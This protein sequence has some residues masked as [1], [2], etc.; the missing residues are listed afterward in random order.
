[1]NIKK[2]YTLLFCV[3]FFAGYRIGAYGAISVFTFTPA[4][5]TTLSNGN[6]YY[7]GGNSYAF[8]IQA[9]DLLAT[10]KSYWTQITLETREVATAR[11]SLVINVA[12][13]T[14]VSN[15]NS[16]GGTAFDV[17]SINDNT[18]DYRYLD[19]T[20][21]VRFRWSCTDFVMSGA[22]VA[23]GAANQIYGAVTANG[24]ATSGSSSNTYAYGVCT[25]I[26]ILNFAQS[27]DAGDARIS[28]WHSAFN[29]T[30]TAVYNVASATVA[31]G[32]GTALVSS[33]ALYY[34][35]G[36]VSSG[37]TS[38]AT[39]PDLTY[40]IPGDPAAFFASLALGDYQWYISLAMTNGQTCTSVNTLS[41]NV[42]RVEITNIEFLNGGGINSP[43]Y[44]NYSLPGT[45]VR[46]SAQMQHNSASLG[47]NRNMY[48]DTTIII[49]DTTNAPNTDIN[50]VIPNNTSQNTILVNVPFPTSSIN[51]D[52]TTPHTYQVRSVSGSMYDSGQNIPARITST[53]ANQIIY[54]DRNDPPGYNASPF[55]AAS[56]PIKTASSLTFI[57]TPLSSLPDP[58]YDDD[59]Y[60]YRIYYKE[61]IAST[62]LI[63]DRSVSGYGPA[64]VNGDMSL[65]STTQATVTNLK[66]LTQ[67]A[68][69]ITAVDVFGQEVNAA[70][71]APAGGGTA[72]TS[73]VSIEVAITDGIAT[74]NDSTFWSNI[75]ASVRPLR[76]TAIKVSLYIL[77]GYSPPDKVNIILYSDSFGNMVNTGTNQLIGTAGT[78]YYRIECTKTAPN[79]YTA[80]IPTTNPQILLGKSSKF[81][82]ELVRS[83]INAYC[84]NNSENETPATADP[85]DYPYRFYI[86]SKPTFTPWPT[87]IL[88]N[89]INNANPVAYPAYYLSEDASVTIKVYDIKGRA[90]NT[91]LE[92]AY[93]KGGQNIKEGGW[94]GVNKTNT[95]VGAGLYY[96]HIE[97]KSVS[98][99]KVILNS[100]QKCVVAK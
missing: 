74:Y 52:T 99:G 22:F 1:M 67:Y 33:A 24:G 35:P 53:P 17:I 3:L 97:A 38:S 15:I 81:L 47:G 70:N 51:P 39:L 68:Y 90:I 72:T 16:G 78:D 62:W 11:Q 56:S 5:F 77:S 2:I 14:V 85:N 34:N 60:T 21:I 54:W 59:F 29:V 66:P 100:F 82:V 13:D 8:R 50:V 61:S 84:D 12:D 95:K 44:R 76:E 79:T 46:I 32:V 36:T 96:I 23:E 75:A 64:G 25:S 91:L 6:H 63:I 31:D 40:A 93:R 43:Y 57:W 28:P 89:V 80:T 27:G 87:R 48:G 19:Y 73:A 41:L 42:N 55:T 45:Q 94:T 49:T 10:G 18:A 98:S 92:N 58:P 20:I 9:T 37:I 86:A 88:N 7:L 83:G 26:R 69:Y 30:G 71:V 4:T 65:I